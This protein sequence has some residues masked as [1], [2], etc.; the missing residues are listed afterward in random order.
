MRKAA[1]FSVL[2]WIFGVSAAN[3]VDFASL[4]RRSVNNNLQIQAARAGQKAA[5]SLVK[6]ARSAYLPQLDAEGARVS[7]DKTVASY[8]PAGTFS[9]Q[10]LVYP[11]TEKNVTRGSITLDY[12]LFDFGGRKSVMRSARAGNTAAAL[13]T[14]AMIRQTGLDLLAA[15]EAARKAEEQLTALETARHSAAEHLKQVK[16]FHREGLVAASDVY[17]LEAL[18]AGL[19]AKL[20]MARAGLQSAE[21][22]LSRLTGADVDA[23]KLAPL[24]EPGTGGQFEAKALENREELKLLGVSE[25]IHQLNAKKIRS[26]FLPHFFVRVQYTDTSDNFVYNHSNTS[27]L[28]GVKLKLFDG[29]QRHYQR[30]SELLQAEAAKFRQRDTKALIRQQL[31]SEEDRFQALAKKVT[32]LKGR[33]KAANENYRVAQLQFNE[34]L[35]SSV[36]LSDAITLRA[37]AE[38]GFYS[39]ED[40]WRAAGLRLRLL[41]ENMEEGFP[42]LA[43]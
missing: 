7:F 17:R 41:S 13:K 12:L 22:A 6:A 14:R 43:E 8:I 3:A 21:R 25:T 38:A 24:P 16:A 2:L 11:L 4:F 30:R 33:L 20:A 29:F 34:H 39:A 19:D 23:K 15:Y 32:A 10:P 28:V 1:V 31:G 35:I 37:E 42:W 5:R 27:F 36:D 9:P 18:A 40:E 26:A